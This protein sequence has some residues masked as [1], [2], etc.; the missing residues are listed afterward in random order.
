M[1]PQRSQPD[2]SFV[3]QGS[4]V[5]SEDS[6]N[7]ISDGDSEASV[8][9]MLVSGSDHEGMGPLAKKRKLFIVK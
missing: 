9:D 7:W 6:D 4:P 8:L 1:S 3:I 2:N 5:F